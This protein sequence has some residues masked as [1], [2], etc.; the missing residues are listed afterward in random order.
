M[1]KVEQVF[2]IPKLARP[3]PPIL[4]KR[5]RLSTLP[6]ETLDQIFEQL[7]LSKQRQITS[8]LLPQAADPQIYE[9]ILSS[10]PYL[11][12]LEIHA[13]QHFPRFVSYLSQPSR[14]LKLTL[15]GGSF[16]ATPN[17]VA[18]LSTLSAL[19]T[20][21]VDCPFP[22]HDPAV[23]AALRTLPL[24]TL[25][26]EKHSTAQYHKI[27]QLIGDD[28]VWAAVEGWDFE[29]RWVWP[30]RPEELGHQDVEYLVDKAAVGIEVRGAAVEALEFEGHYQTQKQRYHEAV[31]DIQGRRQD[32]YYEDEDD[33]AE[34]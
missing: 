27:L 28:P 1:V 12:G 13:D 16:S 9:D 7:R 26:I 34:W 19:P 21:R 11:E 23:D 31:A 24:E 29:G 10:V 18:A 32:G 17:S 5:D 14:L 33:H 22:F 20:L 4:S 3:R 30:Q 8:L 2:V 25:R 15:S 6:S